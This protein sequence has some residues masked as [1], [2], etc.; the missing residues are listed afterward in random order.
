MTITTT[1]KSNCN[2]KTSTIGSCN[3][4][5]LLMRD[6]DGYGNATKLVNVINEKESMTKDLTNIIKKH[7]FRA[8]NMK[9]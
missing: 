3:D 5:L 1:I 6:K 4:F 7:Q 2:N 9:F 8:L